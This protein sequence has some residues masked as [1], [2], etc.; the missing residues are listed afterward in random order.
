M[1]REKD[2][3]SDNRIPMKKSWGRFFEPVREL[4]ASMYTGKFRAT[5]SPTA[6]YIHREDLRSP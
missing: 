6:R 5:H 3:S 4:K 2:Y 1:T